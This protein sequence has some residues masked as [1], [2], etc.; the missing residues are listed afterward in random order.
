M[1]LYLRVAV[2]GGTY[3]LE[4][5]RILELGETMRGRDDAGRGAP[6]PVVDLRELFGDTDGGFGSCVLFAQ[7]GGRPAML[8]VDRV[9]GLVEVG[10]AEFRALPPIGP[11][12]VLLDA[13]LAKLVEQ[14][15]PLLR[16]RGE[17]VLAFAAPAGAGGPER[18]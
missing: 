5:A 11:V 10:D 9:G 14:Q 18:G 6:V 13:V 2:G 4:A 8:V 17:R 7:T 15:P 12:G 3:L 16:L 1:S